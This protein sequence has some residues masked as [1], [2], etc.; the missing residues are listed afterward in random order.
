MSTRGF[1]MLVIGYKG[2]VEWSLVK[3]AFKKC[4]DLNSLDIDRIVKTIKSGATVK[5]PDDFVL[6]DELKDLGI[7]IQ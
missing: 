6:H 2:T 1:T 5:I 3:A 7:K 4:T